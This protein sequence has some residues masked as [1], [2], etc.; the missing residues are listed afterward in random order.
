MT[1]SSS[2]RSYSLSDYSW[3]KCYVPTYNTD[4]GED[5]ADY[6]LSGTSYGLLGSESG[7]TYGSHGTARGWAAS[8]SQAGKLNGLY[9]DSES[10]SPY[11]QSGIQYPGQPY[12]IRPTSNTEPNSWSFSGMASLPTP[13]PLSS[14]DR[15]L[16][17]VPA[18]NRTSTAAI[19]QARSCDGLPFTA[20]VT[21][22][23]NSHSAST[24]P[25]AS[26]PSYAPL[27][28][29]SES[30]NSGGLQRSLSQQN[31]DIYP[32]TADGWTS[33]NLHTEPSL[34]SQ[35]S[36]SDLYYGPSSDSSRKT[37]HGGRSNAESTLANG[38]IYQVPYQQETIQVSRNSSLDLSHVA[39]HRPS[40]G[41]L[42][43]A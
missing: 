13:S 29:S 20:N 43:A 23:Q 25:L 9:Y 39:N 22:P 18:S 8:V 28:G 41:S 10:T 32:A 4:Y 14:N 33:G 1:L 30:F 15:L 16:P 38:H 42:R 6:A 24:S 36:S 12:S 34:R 40:N 2:C 7:S 37:S 3:Q 5:G 11:T 27:S 31:H 21:K 17:P 26:G 19:P 35:D